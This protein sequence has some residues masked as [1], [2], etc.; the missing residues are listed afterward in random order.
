MPFLAAYFNCLSS[1]VRGSGYNSVS[2][3]SRRRILLNSID[4]SNSSGEKTVTNTRVLLTVRAGNLPHFFRTSS[5]TISPIANPTPDGTKFPLYVPTFKYC[6]GIVVQATDYAGIEF[7]V[8]IKAVLFDN[9]QDSCKPFG[10]LISI[11]IIQNIEKRGYLFS[12]KSSIGEYGVKV[13][14][15]DL[16]SLVDYFYER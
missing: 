6:T 12:A 7:Y 15:G 9:I 8:I 13:V 11:F 2:V 5:I 16:R 14:R 4:L 10:I 1:F 3:F